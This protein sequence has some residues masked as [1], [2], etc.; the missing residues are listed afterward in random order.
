[1]PQ[2]AV[3]LKLPKGSAAPAGWTLVRQLRSKNVYKKN[4]PAPVPQADVDALIAGFAQM[5]IAAQA[6][7]VDDLAAALAGLQVSEGGT[8]RRR[9]C[10]KNSH[11][12]RKMSQRRRRA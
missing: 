10:R 11:K 6:N 3:I 12:N 2:A 9:G 8:R 4:A 7:P 5:G 1:M